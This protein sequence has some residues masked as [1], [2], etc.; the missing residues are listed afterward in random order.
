MRDICLK[1][2]EEQPTKEQLEAMWRHIR[3]CSTSS[4]NVEQ[5]LSAIVLGTRTP[6]D[7]IGWLVPIQSSANTIVQY[8][9]FAYRPKIPALA[10]VGSIV[11]TFRRLK[12]PRFREMSWVPALHSVCPNFPFPSF[13]LIFTKHFN[14]SY[15]ET[16]TR[17]V[18]RKQYKP[19]FTNG[20][21]NACIKK[22][23]KTK[24]KVDQS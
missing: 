12:K 14:D 1:P 11:W 10:V 13:I 20:L 19:W 8:Q 15:S 7:Y 17:N 18:T 5:K 6:L 3:H 16:T 21:I 4:D 9:V 24:R 2:H 22:F 23:L